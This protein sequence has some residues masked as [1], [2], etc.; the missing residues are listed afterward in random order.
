MAVSINKPRLFIEPGYYVYD[1][2]VHITALNAVEDGYD[3]RRFDCYDDAIKN[4]EASPAPERLSID[5]VT[6][7]HE[8]YI[9]PEVG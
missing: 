9:E 3:C 1:A 5:C 2:R 4:L 7:V 8:P 6:L